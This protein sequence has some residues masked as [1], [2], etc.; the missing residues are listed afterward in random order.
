LRPLAL[1]F[2][3]GVTASLWSVRDRSRTPL[4]RAS[5]ASWRSE[6]PTTCSR[7]WTDAES[8]QRDYSLTGDTAFLEAYPAVRE[9]YQ[10][11]ARTTA[12][13]RRDRLLQQSNLAARGCRWIEARVAEMSQVIALRRQR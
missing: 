4:D 13:A 1:L 11:R 2:A 3:L 9:R 10:W 6:A 7:F 8:G 5:T 12:S